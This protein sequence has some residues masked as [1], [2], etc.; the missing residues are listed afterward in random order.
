VTATTRDFAGA[1]ERL[2]ACGRIADEAAVSHEMKWG[3]VLPALIALGQ[4]AAAEGLVRIT[5]RGRY[6]RRYERV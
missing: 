5:Y 1:V 4:Q 2:Q 6:E 3:L